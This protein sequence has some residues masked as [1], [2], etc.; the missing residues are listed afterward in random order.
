MPK[1]PYNAAKV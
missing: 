1:A